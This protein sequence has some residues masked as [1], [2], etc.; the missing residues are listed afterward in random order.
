VLLTGAG[1][2]TDADLAALRDL[3][4]TGVVV[5]RGDQRGAVAETRTT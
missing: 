3:G 5:H 4:G 2:V 1:S